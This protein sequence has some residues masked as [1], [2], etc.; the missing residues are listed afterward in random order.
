M[1]LLACDTPPSDNTGW[2]GLAIA[3]I[4]VI[5]FTALCGLFMWLL[6]RP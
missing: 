1:L 6:S 5:S 4:V 2:I 3:A